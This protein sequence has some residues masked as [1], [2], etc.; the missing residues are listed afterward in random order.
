MAEPLKRTSKKWCVCGFKCRKQ[1]GEF[2]TN[3]HQAGTHHKA[4]KKVVEVKT[5]VKT[6]VGDP[7]GRMKK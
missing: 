4:G 6:N 7:N 1:K 2:T 3:A 5:G